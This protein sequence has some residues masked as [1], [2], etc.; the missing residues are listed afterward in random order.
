MAYSPLYCIVNDNVSCERE[1]RFFT[2]HCLIPF[3]DEG[4]NEFFSPSGCSWCEQSNLTTLPNSVVN[5]T[6]TKIRI[7][8]EEQIIKNTYVRVEVLIYSIWK[9]YQEATSESPNGHT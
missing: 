5:F 6:R 1:I 8:A 2:F 4:K 3:Y 7:S 9:N